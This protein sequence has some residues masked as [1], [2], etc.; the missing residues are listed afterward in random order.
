ML[1]ESITLELLCMIA[2]GEV[3]FALYAVWEG[4]LWSMIGLL[5]AQTTSFMALE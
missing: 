1:Q 3:M 5:Q 4:F 2:I